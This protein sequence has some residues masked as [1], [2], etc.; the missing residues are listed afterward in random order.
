[1]AIDLIDKNRAMIMR[2]FNF[3]FEWRPYSPF[4]FIMYFFM[5]ASI[6]MFFYGIKPYDL[7]FIRI[8]IF[9]IIVLY[10]GF[11]AAIIWNDICDADIDA[12]VH[13]K[14]AIPMKKI[15]KK[16][17]F[18]VAIIFSALVLI[19]SYL[20]NLRC[21]LFVGFAALFV[22]FHN[23][24]LKRRVKFPAY[25]EIVTPFQWTIFPIFGFLAI[26]NSS[27][28]NMMLLVAFTY[29]A[30]GAH[31][32]PEGIHD[33]EGDRRAGLMTYTTSF[34]EKSAAR[35][36]FLMLF[37]AGIIGIILYF[38]T[39]LTPI[40]LI[41]FLSLWVY[42]LFFSYKFLKMNRE[43]TKKN[44]LSTGLKI[45]RFFWATYVFIFFDILIQILV[46]HFY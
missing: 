26:N 39:I 45:Y 25:S 5:Y 38:K 41:L 32:Y 13:P 20:V 19:F 18:G 40:F 2:P 17:F 24:Y 30:D 14:R 8:I 37:I 4:R 11:F 36:S 29:L 46:L 42:T 28:V 7:D 6:P 27:I 15:S 35:M 21:F 34:G 10:S 12:I 3:L 9:T 43:N 1:M 22:A 16:K 44:G 23:K 33:A 31:D